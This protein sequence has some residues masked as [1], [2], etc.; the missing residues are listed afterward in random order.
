MVCCRDKTCAEHQARGAIHA[1]PPHMRA[2][3]TDSGWGWL[4][5][6]TDGTGSLDVESA[7]SGQTESI[8]GSVNQSCQSEP[9]RKAAEPG[10]RNEVLARHGMASTTDA[11]AGGLCAKADEIPSDLANDL[12]VE[13][14]SVMP[15]GHAARQA[16]CW[17]RN[18]RTN[19]VQ[20]EVAESR[21]FVL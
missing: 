5:Y 9:S 2:E 10:R 7:H 12:S 3:A 15:K 19:A 17:Y 8:G 1:V 6:Y 4:A 20:V 14:S 16:K 13:V 18:V 21:S 11:L